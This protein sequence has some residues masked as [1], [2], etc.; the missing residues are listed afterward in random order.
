MDRATGF[1]PVGWEFESLRGRL[2]IPS[3]NGQDTGLRNLELEFESP[4]DRH[5]ALVAQRTG[6][7]P[8]EQERGSSSLPE[9]VRD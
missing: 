4:R 5:L 6:R 1:Y 7:L 9:R 3:S 2:L 8:P